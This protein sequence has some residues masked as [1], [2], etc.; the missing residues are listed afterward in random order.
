MTNLTTLSVPRTAVVDQLHQDRASAG[1]QI[2]GIVTFCLLT[3]LGAQVRIYLWEVPFTLQTVAV[4]GSGLYL[5][6]RN[7]MASQLLYLTLGL[8][9]P[10]YAGDGYGPAYLLGAA[11]AG[12][13]FGFPVAAAVVGAVSK[14][15]NSLTGSVLSMAAGSICLFSIGV[16][17]LHFAAGHE[18]WLESIDKGWLRFIPVDILKVL[19]LGTVYTGTR[20]FRAE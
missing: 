4:Y 7:G 11:S 9:F 1:L 18:T 13:L 2:A 14:K 17:W 20:A 10:V 19:L 12:Y 16:L 3:V 8:L 15:W 5:G 6:W